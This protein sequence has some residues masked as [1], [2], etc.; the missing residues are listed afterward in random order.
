VTEVAGRVEG[1]PLVPTARQ[2][3]V[4]DLP[5]P[6][7]LE[8][9]ADGPDPRGRGGWRSIVQDLDPR[10]VEGPKRVL[11][12]L[13]L[14]SLFLRIDDAALG[15]LLP[16]IRAE[17]GVSLTFFGIVSALVGI[18]NIGLLIPF[19]YLAD[20]VKRVWMLRVGTLLTA[21][22]VTVQ[23]VV[24]SVT[25][26]VGARL[27]NGVGL[28]VTQPASFPLLA[29]WFPPGGRTRVFGIYF[30]AAQLGLVVGPVTAGVLGDAF[31]WRAALLFLGGL[32][33]AVGLL[34]FLLQRAAARRLRA[35]GRAER[36]DPPA[37]GFAE[38]Y[39]AS[40]SVVD[41]APL[42]VRTPLLSARGTFTFLVMPSSCSRSTACRSPS[43]ASCRRQRHGGPVALLFA[44]VIGDR[45]LTSRPGRYMLFMGLGAVAQAAVVALSPYARPSRGD[46]R[47][48]SHR[49]RRGRAAAGLLLP[50]RHRRA[51]AGAR[52][53]SS[54]RRRRGSCSGVIGTPFLLAAVEGIGLQT[55]RPGLRPAA[56]AGRAVP[57]H[58]SRPAW[59]ATSARA[60]PPTPPRTSAQAREQGRPTAGL[61]RRAGGRTRR[62]GAV[63]RRPRRA[64]R[65]GRA[66]G[67][68][69]RR[70][71]VDAAA[72]AGRHQRAERRRGLLRRP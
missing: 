15:V 24:P 67:R 45:L 71:Q 2:V 36:P 41:P 60:A 63:R 35:A 20:R 17:F 8:A 27:A 44:G 21:A 66:P 28:A 22:T 39:R 54:R 40:A 65:R 49:R 48:P 6:V 3:A 43:S 1:R 18:I 42:L 34:T 51:V 56:A 58:R 57:R 25:T 70:R 37:P 69:E 68:H 46:P 72:R 5:A 4:G 10:R 26:L 62:A 16:S 59:S 7:V 9:P 30:A 55:G 32:A 29:D 14:T 19:G 11:L 38:S 61:P 47:L 33:T 53:R 50:D 13:C 64:G 12:I 52:A 31:G 23:G